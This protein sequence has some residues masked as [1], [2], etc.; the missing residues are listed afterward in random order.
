MEESVF[1]LTLCLGRDSR[2]RQATTERGIER[3]D[4]GGEAKGGKGGKAWA[5]AGLAWPR[6]GASAARAQVAR[7]GE[8]T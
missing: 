2:Q 6:V 5:T 7:R 8:L 4:G 1:V 3:E